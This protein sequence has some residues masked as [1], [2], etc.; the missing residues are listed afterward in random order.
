LWI[1]WSAFVF[2]LG[3]AR[4]QV[5]FLDVSW[6]QFPFIIVLSLVGARWGSR[7]ATRDYGFL[8]AISFAG[9]VCTTVVV[10]FFLPASIAYE[11]R[12]AFP[13]ALLGMAALAIHGLG[14]IAGRSMRAARWRAVASVSVF[15]VWYVL[16]AGPATTTRY[17][18]VDATV[19][20]GTEIS[21]VFALSDHPNRNITILEREV[22]E[23]RD[24]ARSLQG[25]NVQIVFSKKYQFGT[26]FY[27][28]QNYS[29]E[30]I[31]ALTP[32]FPNQQVQPNFDGTFLEKLVPAA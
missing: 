25:E 31:G 29:I 17:W 24:Y 19:S 30:R 12:W 5:R 3:T 2:I 26:P 18:I 22:R 20:G 11:S 15:G 21:V 23:F 27:G 4:I 14:R 8:D 32:W 9:T 10:L 1:S 7:A 28:E 6:T 13:L 16:Y